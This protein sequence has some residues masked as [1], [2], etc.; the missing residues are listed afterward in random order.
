MALSVFKV[1]FRSA[2]KWTLSGQP[3]PPHSKAERRG[4]LA[5]CLRRRFLEPTLVA[6]L[7]QG[8]I[9]PSAKV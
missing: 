9:S 6:G 5:A 8:R 1:D 7:P 3:P 4:W 2:S